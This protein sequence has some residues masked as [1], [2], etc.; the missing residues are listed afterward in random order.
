MTNNNCLNLAKKKYFVIA[1]SPHGSVLLVCDWWI[2]D[3]KNASLSFVTITERDQ[4]WSPL[5]LEAANKE[6]VNLEGPTAL[7]P[8]SDTYL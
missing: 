7:V 1:V 8:H 6:N 5:H 3:T 4:F 2:F